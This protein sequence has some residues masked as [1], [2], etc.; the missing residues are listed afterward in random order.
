MTGKVPVNHLQQ[1]PRCTAK[2]KRSGLRCQAPAVR[3]KNVC[4]M[5][6]AFAGAPKGERNG[7]W[8]HG[9]HSEDFEALRL[10]IRGLLAA[11][12]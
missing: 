12:K 11:R 9:I 2:S 10:A 7:R 6:G 8:K 3:G 1:A 5:H 4:R